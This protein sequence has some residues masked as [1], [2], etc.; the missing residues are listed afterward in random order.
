MA[1][2][3]GE[4]Y[5][6][7]SEYGAWAS[8]TTA[9]SMAKSIAELV[10]ISNKTQ[11]QVV[12]ELQTNGKI[13]EDLSDQIS[14]GKSG[15]GE[16]LDKAAESALDTAAG[17]DKVT[18][19]LP[20]F[21]KWLSEKLPKSMKVGLAGFGMLTAGIAHAVAIVEQT[22]GA[23]QNMTDQGISFT[24]GVRDV[25]S[26]LADT[27]MTL[28]QL[29]E[30]TTKYSR[31]IGTN[32]WAAINKLTKSVNTAGLGFI[33]Y[34]LTTEQATEFTAEY[35]E[36]QRLAGVFGAASQR[37]QSAALQENVERLTAYSKT[38]NVSR[39]AMMATTTEM[40]SREDVQAQFALMTP[41]ARKKAQAAFSATIQGFASLG[42]AGETFGRLLTDMIA[43]PTAE[44]SEAFKQ[45]AQAA[46]ELAQD[47]AGVSK[48]VRAG[49]KVSQEEIMGIL[50]RAGK[51][52]EVLEAL[53]RVGG[54]L[55]DM[56]NKVLVASTAR[57]NAEINELRM[58]EEYQ[59][60]T[61][62][63]SEA[64][65]KKNQATADNAAQMA[66][67]R[68]DIYAK[69]QAALQEQVM[70]AFLDLIG[71]DAGTGL[72]GMIKQMNGLIEKIRQ[73][74]DMGWV[75]SFR[76]FI[77]GEGL[78]GAAKA[79]AALAGI[80][81]LGP[82]ALIHGIPLLAKGVWALGKQMVTGMPAVRTAMASL[83]TNITTKLIPALGGWK[84]ALGKAGA[85][86]AAFSAGYA[87]GGWIYKKTAVGIQDKLADWF[88]DEQTAEEIAGSPTNVDSWGRPR[89]PEAQK[90][91]EEF[92]QKNRDARAAEEAEKRGENPPKDGVATQS[93][94]A[95]P[96]LSEADIA[97]L[98]KADQQLAWLKK[99][100][101]GIEANAGMMA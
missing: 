64:G 91:H 52:K 73:F 17:L 34:G 43:N 93:T 87:I 62:D 83:G 22:A 67:A 29:Q 20:T 44:A 25:Q 50:E 88:G 7:G 86:A 47:L 21:G 11:Q 46:P 53:T 74:D 31:V 24:G 96:S 57:E 4:V 9:V 3:D 72:K 98:D 32:S 45:V 26:A 97:K 82:T 13:N 68:A 94:P 76:D 23:M 39:K 81:L 61:G 16:D 55:G 101:R 12:K 71:D 27:G 77:G 65:F 36:Q 35:L 28:D 19:E 5:I 79:L 60:K 70:N 90:A 14:K 51:N 100:S 85:A 66:A 10:D 48:R 99:I 2:T 6:T 8:E 54:E 89:T 49:E 78:G 30:I 58:R 63:M 69:T 18:K 41:E 38:L 80:I 75:K 95:G 42:P 40:L 33:K 59:K 37:G 92:R 15:L 84:G 56:A 1:E